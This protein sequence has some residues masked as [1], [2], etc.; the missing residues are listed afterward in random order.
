ML[1]YLCRAEPPRSGRG[2]RPYQPWGFLTAMIPPA[3]A[4]GKLRP[5]SSPFP[6][7]GTCRLLL[8]GCRVKWSGRLR[9]GS[10]VGPAV[11]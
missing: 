3:R 11:G 6:T 8:A 5:V 9:S 4:Y 1:S 7:F 10:A 2:P